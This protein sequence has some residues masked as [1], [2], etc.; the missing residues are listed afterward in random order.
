MHCRRTQNSDL[1]T[2]PVFLISINFF[3]GAID[4]IEFYIIPDLSKLANIKVWEAAAVQ[5]FFSLSVAGG[6]LITLASYNKFKNNV[7][8]DTFIV[9]FGNCLTSIFAG[10]YFWLLSLKLLTTG[11][12]I[13]IKVRILWEGH[14][15]WKNL[16]LKIWRY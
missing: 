2:V 3:L 7:I 14:K 5:I 1:W 15:I 6:G 9:C 8:R 16:P 4:G 13:L 12:N 11:W 10:L